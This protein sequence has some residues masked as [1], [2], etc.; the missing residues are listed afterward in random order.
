MFLARKHTRHSLEEI[1]GY[2]G[3]RDHTTVMH[4]LKAVEARLGVESVLN[5]EI[6]AI[7]V[8]LAS[9]EAEPTRTA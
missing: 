6:E 3:G 5:R 4:A 9:I 2:L 8:K 1:G 7:E